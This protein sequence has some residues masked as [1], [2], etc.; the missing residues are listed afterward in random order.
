M[1]RRAG[2][3][4]VAVRGNPSWSARILA[5]REFELNGRRVEAGLWS[6]Q[7]LRVVLYLWTMIIAGRL[8]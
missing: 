1:L 2:P 8:E 7:A 6:H 5:K 4:L 3:T